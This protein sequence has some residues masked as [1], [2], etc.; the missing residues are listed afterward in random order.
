MSSSYSIGF[1]HTGSISPCINLFVFVRTYF[2]T[3]YVVLAY[4][5]HSGVGLMGL[6]PSP[7]D[8]LSFTAVTLVVGSFD[9]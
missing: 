7:Y 9:L 6:K 5:E 1:C 8:P 2:M 3:A 4:C